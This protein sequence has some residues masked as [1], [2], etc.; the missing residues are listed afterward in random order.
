MFYEQLKEL[1][2][3]N[4]TTP[5]AFVTEKLG[6]SSSKITAW[7]NGSIPKYGILKQI[8]EHFKVPVSYLFIESNEDSDIELEL[9]EI[10]RQLN[11][12][13]QECV[14]NYAKYTLE[15]IRYQKYTDISKDA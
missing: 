13:G 7:K 1:C 5:T 4:K 8:S 11:H 10:F 6:L 3:R 15:D 12:D 2:K 9:L 14:R